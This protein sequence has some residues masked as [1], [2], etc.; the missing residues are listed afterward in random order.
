LRFNRLTFAVEHIIHERKI[1]IDLLKSAMGYE[2][3]VSGMVNIIPLPLLK[4]P[5]TTR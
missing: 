2:N 5:E 4:V 1:E 3:V